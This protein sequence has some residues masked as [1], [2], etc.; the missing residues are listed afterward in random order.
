MT[1]DSFSRIMAGLN[2]ALRHASGEDVPGMVIHRPGFL[3]TLTDE[4]RAQALA[5]DGG[6]QQ[7][8]W[9]ALKEGE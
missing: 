3:A 1:D 6:D 5:H 2:E 9:D 4:Q 7:G 8:R